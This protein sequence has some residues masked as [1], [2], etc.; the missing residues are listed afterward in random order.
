MSDTSTLR[1]LPIRLYLFEDEV[2]RKAMLDPSYTVSSDLSA[3]FE[4]RDLRS[5]ALDRIPEKYNARFYVRR[6]QS[7]SSWQNLICNAVSNEQKQAELRTLTQGAS[8]GGLL[9][10]RVLDKDWAITFGSGRYFLNESRIRRDFGFRV[11]LNTVRPDS[12]RQI[13]F[14]TFYGDAKLTKQQITKG[15]KINYYDIEMTEN[16]L[17]GIAGETEGHRKQVL[18]PVLAGGESLLM[19]VKF[20]LLNPESL[21]AIVLEAY[22]SDAYETEASRQDLFSIVQN[23]HRVEDDDLKEELG[24][25]FLTDFRAS[26]F[27]NMQL[28]YPNM[29]LWGSEQIGLAAE[30]PM[31]EMT[32]QK[33]RD[34]FARD[35]FGWPA[36]RRKKIF[37]MD[38]HGS[39]RGEWPLFKS[40]AYSKSIANSESGKQI[41]YSF[42]FGQ[43]YRIS[44]IL[45]A[46]L[47]DFFRSVLEHPH[48]FPACTINEDEADYAR[49][50]CDCT[51]TGNK[52]QSG[53]KWLCLDRRT[54]APGGSNRRYEPCDILIPR[55]TPGDRTALVH[56]KKTGVEDDKVPSHE[57]FSHLFVQGLNSA[58]SLISD[59]TY[60]QQVRTKVQRWQKHHGLK[61][62]ESQIKGL[63]QAHEIKIVYIL[64][65]TGDYMD[66][67]PAFS[68]LT[69]RSC[70]VKLRKL[71]FQV[72]ICLLEMQ[73]PLPT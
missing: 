46:K 44:S 69:M 8:A 11:V 28:A 62:E 72:S 61:L 23:L 60:R 52:W 67:V 29:T 9:L 5:V 42:M 37:V 13:S 1:R 34:G 38:E 70:I 22:K 51:L 12:I 6:T 19:L 33:I 58:E 53:P 15:Q 50:V 32:L 40:I 47:K 20:N 66:K 24:R 54:I 10:L 45:V 71:G 14:H 59:Q 73:A 3:A 49:R 7:V 17:Q 16:I 56:I 35:D 30:E 25:S 21:L 2:D 57:N 31:E 64:G 26:N 36:L 39:P 18:G 65:M 27:E 48:D 55:K 68:L 41:D 63:S 43:W 4:S